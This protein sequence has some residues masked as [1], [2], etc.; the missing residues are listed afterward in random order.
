MNKDFGNAMAFL[1]S[2]KLKIEDIE[3]NTHLMS[4]N[5]LE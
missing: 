3:I 4:V 1:N 5:N 2:A